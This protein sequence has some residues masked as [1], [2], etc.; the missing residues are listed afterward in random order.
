MRLRPVL[1]CRLTGAMRHDHPPPDLR[2][3]A[4]PRLDRAGPGQLFPGWGARVKEPPRPISQP[5]AS[6]LHPAP[7]PEAAPPSRLRPAH[8]TRTDPVQSGPAPPPP[9]SPQVPATSVPPLRWLSTRS[10][11]APPHV[12]PTP[13][14]ARY[15]T[16]Y[17]RDVVQ[18]QQTLILPPPPP[19]I[20]YL[21]PS[22]IADGVGDRRAGV[23]GGFEGWVLGACAG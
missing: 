21:P 3:R 4:G 16:R 22:A 8:P 7:W 2:G 12:R 14:R 5:I 1:A 18:R 11:R 23:W 6:P 19:P 17:D 10:P 13:L 15:P 20:C 9:P